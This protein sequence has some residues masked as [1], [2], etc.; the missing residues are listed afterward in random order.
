MRDVFTEV[1]HP[2]CHAVQLHI[3]DGENFLV[4]FLLFLVAI[5]E[6]ENPF[7]VDGA[8][9][10]RCRAVSRLDDQKE[11]SVGHF[12]G[13]EA[14]AA[15]VYQCLYAESG[16]NVPR[17]E[18]RVCRHHACRVPV[19]VIVNDGQI[20]DYYGFERVDMDFSDAYSS[21]NAVFQGVQCL[22][23]KEGLDFRGLYG[24]KRSGN[25]CRHDNYQQI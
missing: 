5:A 11:K 25:E 15:V 6:S 14:D 22:F 17:A 10:V 3:R 12:R 16:G 13:R 8:R 7:Q 19:R 23:R 18:K 2:E 20:F 9:S 1:P 24:N 4:V 21:V